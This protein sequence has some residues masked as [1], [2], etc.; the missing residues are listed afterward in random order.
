MAKCIL[1]NARKGKRKCFVH[2]G[3]IC[4]LCCGKIRSSE[5]CVGCAY[6]QNEKSNRKYNNIGYYSLQKMAEDTRLQD[7]AQVIESAICKFDLDQNRCLNDRLIIKILERLMDKYHF[8]DDPIKFSNDLVT[9]GFT[10]VDN[11]VQEQL[12]SLSFEECAAFFETIYRSVLRRTVRDREYLS[13]IHSQ[14]GI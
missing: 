3:F 7:S 10:A 9:K 4:S 14:F 6:F 2:E 11:V 8:K 1:C 12:S 5:K 13:F